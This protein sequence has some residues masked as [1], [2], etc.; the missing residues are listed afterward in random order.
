[1]VATDSD[2]MDVILVREEDSLA[3]CYSGRRFLS[4]V[5]YNWLSLYCWEQLREF[6]VE[7]KIDDVRSSVCFISITFGAE[8]N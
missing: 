6:D 3:V 8:V 4:F 7:Y 2:A 1:M 5:G